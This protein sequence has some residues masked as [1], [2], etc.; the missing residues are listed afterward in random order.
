MGTSCFV[1]FDPD[2]DFTFAFCVY[3]ILL[4]NFIARFTPGI[5]AD[6]CDDSNLIQA[7]RKDC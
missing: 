4:A 1:A 6:C 5:F 2:L 3:P 7:S